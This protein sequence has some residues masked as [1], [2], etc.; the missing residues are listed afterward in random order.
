[1]KH[2]ISNIFLVC[3][4]ELLI[5]QT[6]FNLTTDSDTTFWYNYKNDWAARFKLGVIEKDTFS[7]SFRF[8][9]HGMTIKVARTDNVFFGEIIRFVEEYP[10]KSKKIFT[11]HYKIPS[12]KVIRILGLIDS[13]QIK[14]LPSDKNI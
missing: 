1:M 4:S 2:L 11:S 14:E 5:A 7:Y 6:T 10:S 8:W 13:F 12:N 3:I 9:S